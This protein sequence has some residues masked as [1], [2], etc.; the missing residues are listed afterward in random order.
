MAEMGYGPQAIEKAQRLNRKEGLGRADGD[1][2]VQTLEDALALTFLEHWLETF[3]QRDDHSTEKIVEILR[4][5]MRKMSP[6]AIEKAKS[7]SFSPAIETLVQ[8]AI[9][10]RNSPQQW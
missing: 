8:K 7:L 4:K 10:Q 9:T 2:D 5:T 6:Q 1:P 3:A